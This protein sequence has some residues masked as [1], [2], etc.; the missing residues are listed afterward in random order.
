MI[1]AVVVTSVLGRRGW[2]LQIRERILELYY[3]GVSYA[4][5]TGR[6]GRVEEP[7]DAILR[8]GRVC[9]VC[10]VV[11]CVDGGC[12]GSWSASRGDG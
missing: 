2:W 9:C 3:R 7:G 4:S 8:H 6:A 5:A 1:A 10:G 11:K 12:L